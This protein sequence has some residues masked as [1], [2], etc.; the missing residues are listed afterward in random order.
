MG[1]FDLKNVWS[2]NCRLEHQ[3]LE[4]T[5]TPHNS[6][7]VKYAQYFDISHAEIRHREVNRLVPILLKPQSFTYSCTA[8]C[9][10]PK[11]IAILQDSS[12]IFTGKSCKLGFNSLK[13]W[14]KNS[15]G[16]LLDKIDWK[17]WMDGDEKKTLREDVLKSVAK[18]AQQ[19]SAPA[20]YGVRGRALC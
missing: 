20:R 12:Q 4:I 6:L 18:Q 10:S 19:A 15:W 11:L 16:Q 8:H 5:N 1:L 13:S 14:S 7:R 3:L 2:P 17:N 9:L